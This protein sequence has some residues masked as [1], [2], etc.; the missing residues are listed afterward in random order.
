MLQIFLKYFQVSML[1]SFPPLQGNIL[2]ELN[3]V[4]WNIWQGPQRLRELVFYLT[5]IYVTLKEQL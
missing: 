4:M 2:K 1:P 3:L 5:H